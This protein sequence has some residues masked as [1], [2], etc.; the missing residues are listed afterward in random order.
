MKRREFIEKCAL[1]TAGVALGGLGSLAKANFHVRNNKLAKKVIVLGIDGMDPKLTMK[2]VE[3]GILPNFKKLIDNGG[4]KPLATSLP[5]QSPVAWSNFITGMN[6]GGHGIFDFIHRD[7][8]L[9]LPYL[10]TTKVVAPSKSLKLGDWQ[11]PLNSGKIELLRKG[12]AFWEILEEHDI[13]AKIFK[14]PS[15]YPPVECNSK[16]ISGM[17]T[18][19]ILGTYG[20]F[21]YYTD[22]P[23]PDAENFG[24]GKVYLVTVREN[25]IE[26]DLIGPSNSF[27]KDGESAKIPFTVYRDAVNPVAK[28]V[29]Q[30]KEIL[31]NQG[32]WSDWLQIKFEML[33]HLHSLSGICRFYL[34][35]VHP[36]FK[37]YVTPI[38]VD[39]SDPAIPISTQNYSK[40]LFDAVGPFYTQGFP[41]DTKA[42]SNGVFS[43]EEYLMQAKLVLNERR[44]IFDHEINCFNDGFFFFYFSSIDQDSHM[45]LRMMDKN[46]PLYNAKASPEVKDSIRYLYKQMDEVLAQTMSKVDN[47]TTLMIL[48]D[49]GFAPL[50][51]EFHLSSWLVENGYTTLLDPSRRGEGEFFDNVDWDHT[52][53]YAM[54]LNGLYLNL[55]DREFN[56]VVDPFE[57]HDVL[58]ELVGKLENFRDPLNG[59]NVVK[60]AY[61]PQE[62]YRGNY[63][64]EAP[65]LVIGYQ[66]EYRISDKSTLGEF[67]DK[68]IEDRKDKWSADHCM[69]PSS[70]PGVLFSNKEIVAK[71]PAIENLAATILDEFRIEPLPEMTKEQIFKNT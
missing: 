17:G 52:K 7:P 34:Q 10:S 46:H 62:A 9:F 40:E 70:V 5:P 6:P 49:H 48:S 20:T 41:E 45:L 42:L 15:N 30:N 59:K 35:E 11:I 65:D 69:D 19:D 14:M 55:R 53:A 31:M 32:E 43:D 38:N 68:I 8:E 28:I 25:K 56:G 24:G 57:A 58:N 4:F 27:R 1:G 39:P 51:R 3:E 50:Y 2:F 29:V 60:K 26:A 13:P 67:P 37:L 64:S 71:N 47:Q 44:R 16:T 36:K 66:P 23:P 18:P 12:R 63:I 22:S 61:K 54:G 21:S 33:P